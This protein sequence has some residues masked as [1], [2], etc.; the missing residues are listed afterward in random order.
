M[1]R[2]VHYSFSISQLIPELRHL[3]ESLDSAES[4][5]GVGYIAGAEMGVR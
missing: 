5:S 3:T 1:D 4:G 2:T